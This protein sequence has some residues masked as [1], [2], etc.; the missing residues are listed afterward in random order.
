MTFRGARVT[1]KVARMTSKDHP[2]S[3]MTF[4]GARMNSQD[5]PGCPDVLHGRPDDL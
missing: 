5:H 4:K 1:I 3:R 2:G